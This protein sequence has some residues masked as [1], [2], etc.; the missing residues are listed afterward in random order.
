MRVMLVFDIFPKPVLILFF[1]M[2]AAADLIARESS[3]L[4]EKPD[5]WSELENRY[6]R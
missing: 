5:D 6:A 2:I 1:S 3:V 4:Y